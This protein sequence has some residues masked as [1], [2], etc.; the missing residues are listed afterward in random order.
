MFYYPRL[1]YL[2]LFIFLL[3]LR[4]NEQQQLATFLL[5]LLITDCLIMMQGF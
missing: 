5:I 1:I 3:D 2:A 4:T